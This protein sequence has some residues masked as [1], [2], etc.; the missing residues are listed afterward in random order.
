MRRNASNQPFW[1]GNS[2]TRAP[3]LAR[4][5]DTLNSN[6]RH[7]P[8]MRRIRDMRLEDARK[9]AT[10][11]MRLH[12]LRPD[13]SFRFDRSKVRFGKCN[14][15]KKEISLS[16]HL[17]EL[18]GRE[19]V[20]ETILHE[21]AHALAPRGAG[22]GA[23]WRAVA[24]SLGCNGRRCYGEEVVRPA[25]KYKGTCPSCRKVIYR[26]R[27]AVV[28][29]GRCTPLFDPKYAFIWTDRPRHGG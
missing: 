5:N 17:V 28:A 23:A 16:R 22:H 7:R 21:I 10:Q 1:G 25:P 27:R 20:R 2:D 14:Y 26:H 4:L 24:L 6:C 18:N 13:W 29:C 8:A 11:L 9:L 19:E 12:K 3:R 15:T